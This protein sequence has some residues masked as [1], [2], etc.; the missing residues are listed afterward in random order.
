MSSNYKWNKNEIIK[1][2]INS[3]KNIIK[4]KGNNYEYKYDKDYLKDMI[5]EIFNLP[6]YYPKIFSYILF[7]SDLIKDEEFTKYDLTNFQKDIINKIFKNTLNDEIKIYTINYKSNY[8]YLNN[9]KKFLIQTSPILY[10]EF[11]NV[12]NKNRL[13]IDSNAKNKDFSGSCYSLKD[14]NYYQIINNSYN[15]LLLSISHELVHGV[16]N[17]LS[18]RKFDKDNKVCLYREVGSMLIELFVN[19][20]LYKNK[21][22]TKEEYLF[23]N[24]N[25]YSTYIYYDVELIDFLYRLSMENIDKNIHNIKGRIND[26]KKKNMMYDFELNELNMRP[27]KYHL[28]YFY[29]CAIAI[30]LFNKFKD[31]PKEGIN[32]AFNIMLAI[33]QSNEK[34]LFNKYNIDVEYDI[35]KFKA[36]NIKSLKKK[37]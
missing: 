11:N 6:H 20:Y 16:V 12:I 3:I 26:E 5:S 29:S 37:N 4:T 33:N 10:N 35:N 22:I 24:N 2:Y 18:N 13:Y 30:S 1:E 31:N 7:K 21:L 36:E 15:D 28:I 23:N 14:K 27:L 9:L 34:E 25:L 19:E 17:S 32:A 8:N